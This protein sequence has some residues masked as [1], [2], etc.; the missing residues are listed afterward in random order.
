MK[1]LDERN[2]YISVY[3]CRDMQLKDGTILNAKNIWEEYKELLKNDSMNYA[4][5]RVLLS[6]VRSKMNYFIYEIKQCDFIW[7]D[8]IGEL[9]CI[10]DAEPYFIDGK[11]YA[12]AFE[13]QEGVFI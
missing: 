4:E 2:W 9:Y 3:L 13:Q 8:Q 10:D 11:F 7:N 12:A 1:L 5:K 6:R